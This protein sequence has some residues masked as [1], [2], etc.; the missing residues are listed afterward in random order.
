MAKKNK[1]IKKLSGVITWIILAVILLGIVGLIFAL[2]NG[3]KST[4]TTFML[5]CGKNLYGGE[6]NEIYINRRGEYEF[7]VVDPLSF[8]REEQTLSVKVIPKAT[9]E[10][11]FSYTVDGEEFNY[12]GEK[13]FTDTFD[14]VVY[15]TSFIIVFPD[16]MRITSLLQKQYTGKAVE[17]INFEQKDMP[18]LTLA[19][20]NGDST[21]YLDILCDIYELSLSETNIVF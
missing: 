19:I 10:N 18:Y 9:D 8:T 13:D 20:S 21:I 6:H 16:D 14:I 2:S 4:P 11:N 7:K 5:S 1:A 15:E 12:V 17:F 3:F